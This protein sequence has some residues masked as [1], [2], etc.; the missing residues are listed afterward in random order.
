MV[1]KFRKLLLVFLALTL[2]LTVCFIYAL[3]EPFSYRPARGYFGSAWGYFLE[4]ILTPLILAAPSSLVVMLV[5]YL[6]YCFVL[7][8]FWFVMDIIEMLHGNANGRKDCESDLN[9]VNEPEKPNKAKQE[10]PPKV[11]APSNAPVAPVVTKPN[12]DDARA[13][14]VPSQEPPPHITEVSPPRIL[15]SGPTNER[16]RSQTKQPETKQ[17]ETH[18]L[19]PS[20]KKIHDRYF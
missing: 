5:C 10:T 14:N 7:L 12:N 4:H 19:S 1:E 11:R 2:F 6:V 20:L 16:K 9:K 3:Y 18:K 17:P 8:S 15:P 13:D